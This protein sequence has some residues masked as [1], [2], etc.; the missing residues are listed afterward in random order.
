MADTANAT[1]EVDEQG[2][3]YLPKAVRKKLGFEGERAIVDIEV[4][5]DE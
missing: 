1:V 3:L 4:A 5:Y 2:R